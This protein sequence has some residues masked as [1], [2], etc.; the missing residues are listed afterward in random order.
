[1]KHLFGLLLVPA[2]ACAGGREDYARQ[3]P[4]VLQQAEAGAYRVVLDREIY[5]QTTSPDLRDIDVFNSQGQAVPSALFG[6][7]QPLAQ[8]PR[9]VVLPWFALPAGDA[10]QVRDITL[11]SERDADGRV[12]R[13]EAR[14]GDGAQSSLE[15]KAWLIDASAVDTPLAAVL[16]DW[17]AQDEPLDV[18]YRVEGS[19]DLR[20]WRTLQP[21]AQLLDLVRDGRR[22]RQRR[23]PLDANAKYMR[24][25]PLQAGSRLPLADVRGELVS[26]TVAAIWQSEDLQGR[27]VVDQGQTYYEFTV[28]GRFPMARADVITTGNDAG[29]WTLHSR[30]ADDAPWQMRAGPWVVYEVYEVGGVGNVDRSAPQ[31]LNQITRDR[32]WRLSSQATVPEVPTLRLGYQP[33]VAVFLAQGRPPFALAAGSARASRADAPLPDLVDALRVKKGADW[34]PATATLGA[35]VQLAGDAAFVPRMPERDWK[36]WLLWA[37]LIASALAVA[38]FAASLLRQRPVA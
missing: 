22:L 10:A 17:P 14:V 1:M 5:R 19:D 12:R 2:L 16:L 36:S 33:E 6:P 37:L 23:I 7:Q 29:Q 30:D 9:E 25:L 32:Q 13:V 4:L 38:G 34:Q 8:P 26:T 3:W 24:L 28:D 20:Y 35:G 31:P 27:A 18:A 11:I 15:A 21:R